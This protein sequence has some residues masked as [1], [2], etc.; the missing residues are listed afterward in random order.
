MFFACRSIL[1]KRSRS[2][3]TRQKESSSQVGCHCEGTT[4]NVSTY[5]RA[6]GE[7]VCCA[8]RND[9]HLTSGTCLQSRYPSSSLQEKKISQLWH[10]KAETGKMLTPGKVMKGSVQPVGASGLEVIS[11]RI[12]HQEKQPRVGINQT[13]EL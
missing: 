7:L 6:T 9:C 2:C 8:P 11:V 10:L 1:P 4:P 3:D 12:P 13:M 5:H